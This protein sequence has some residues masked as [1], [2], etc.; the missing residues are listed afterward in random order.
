M[1]EYVTPVESFKS[2]RVNLGPKWLN[3]EWIPGSL[4]GAVHWSSCQFCH[5]GFV[6][7][8][9]GTAPTSEWSASE[10]GGFELGGFKLC[11]RLLTT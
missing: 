1:W 2:T 10:L 9:G 8:E 5:A 6:T 7:G 4:P 3:Q 11:L